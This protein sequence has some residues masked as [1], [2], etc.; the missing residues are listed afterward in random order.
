M[1]IAVLTMAV[2]NSVQSCATDDDCD[3]SSNEVCCL[4]KNVC[5]VPDD[6]SGACG[7]AT[8][9]DCDTDSN[10]VCLKNVCE[11][12]GSGASDP[13]AT[14]IALASMLAA[15]LLCNA[16]YCFW[17]KFCKKSSTPPPPVRIRDPNLDAE[18]GRLQGDLETEQNRRIKAEALIQRAKGGGIRPGD[19]PSVRDVDRDVEKLA[20]HAIKWTEKACAIGGSHPAVPATVKGILGSTFL[21]CREEVKRCLDRR[22]QSLSEFLGNDEPIVLSEGDAMNLDTQYVLYE[23]L[24]RNFRTIVPVE[25]NHMNQLAGG[26][27]QR[28]GAAADGNLASKLIFG[29]A[30]PSF[31]NLMKKY[32]MVFVEMALQKPA[33]DFNNDLGKNEVF[34]PIVHRDWAQHMK[35]RVGPQCCVVFP[36][37]LRQEGRPDSNA[38]TGVVRLPA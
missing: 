14:V 27:Q 34:D 19:F 31:D 32:I 35:A 4:G 20:E 24:C 16:A 37:V 33:M 25:P 15:L 5:E 9:D 30:W 12:H 13:G 36:K 22:L 28:C 1:L 26:I 21:V 10:E 6:A 7:C 23:C 2:Y 17:C 38:K 8:N 18:L 3:T 29:D 11:V